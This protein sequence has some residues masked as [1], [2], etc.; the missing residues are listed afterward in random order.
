MEN[1]S[2]YWI[3]ELEHGRPRRRGRGIDSLWM[4]GCKFLPKLITRRFS[5]IQYS[6]HRSSGQQLNYN[7]TCNQPAH[8]TFFVFGCGTRTD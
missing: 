8:P 1:G 4:Q 3:S 7:G 2:S 6:V 5:L